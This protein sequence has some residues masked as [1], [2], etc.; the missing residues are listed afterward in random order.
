MKILVLGNGRL[1]KEICNQTGWENISRKKDGID[2][3]SFSLW[4]NK[5]N[6]YDVILNCIA[7]TN[8]YSSDY[9]SMIRINYEF[10]TQLTKYCNDNNSKLVHISTD[11]VY[12]NSDEIASEESVAIPDKNWYSLSKL[13]ADEHIRLFSKNYL[14]CRLSH[15]P[16]PFP[17]DSAWTDVITNADYTDTISS[18]VIELIQN[19]AD[20]LYN[21]G[22]R[23]KTIY[24]LAKMSNPNIKESLAPLHIPK[25]VSM[26]ISKLN[27]FLNRK[28]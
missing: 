5:L 25:N 9:M 2:V 16:N 20:G 26:D 19:N 4:S 23:E 3:S 1:G 10:V 7:N 22:T 21:V 15:K 24:E 11:Y 17:Y 6:D 14:I 27:N 13:L 28:G 12:A 18:L 8:T